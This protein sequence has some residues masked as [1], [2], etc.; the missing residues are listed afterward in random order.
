MLQRYSGRFITHYVFA[1]L[2][3]NILVRLRNYRVSIISVKRENFTKVEDIVRYLSIERLE[4]IKV[5]LETLGRISDNNINK[6]LRSLLL[7]R[8]H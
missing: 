2:I 3:F 7:Y 8:F 4:A 6:L 5:K 1:F